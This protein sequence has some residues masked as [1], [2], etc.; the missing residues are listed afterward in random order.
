MYSKLTMP[1]T[2]APRSK[3]TTKSSPLSVHNTLRPSPLP[4]LPS[5][6]CASRSLSKLS[7][8]AFF[9]VTRFQSL[10]LF[11]PLPTVTIN[12]ILGC[13]AKSFTPAGTSP[14]AAV[15]PLGLPAGLGI[16]TLMVDRT[17]QSRVREIAT[18]LSS[19]AEKSL[20]FVGKC[21][22][23]TAREW[24][25]RVPSSRFLGFSTMAVL[26]RAGT[27]CRDFVPGG[28]ADMLYR[29]IRSSEPPVASTRLWFS[30]D[31]EMAKERME[32]E[33]AE[34]RK[35]SE[36]ATLGCDAPSSHFGSPFAFAEG[37]SLGSLL[38]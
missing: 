9:P 1:N 28:V 21:S 29:F 24:W 6:T 34:N 38:T 37:S 7:T 20:P 5:P 15:S 36:K 12:F 13:M 31:C 4:Y 23:V 11:S 25:S 32:D 27:L 35:V 8:P 17:V 2:T 30:E 22:L 3:P 33:W 10:M 14:G 26:E 16:G 18:V 19:A